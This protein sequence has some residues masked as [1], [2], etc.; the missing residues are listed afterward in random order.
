[1]HVG[2]PYDELQEAIINENEDEAFV[3]LSL[4]DFIYFTL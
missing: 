1:M 4:F 3:I 2:W